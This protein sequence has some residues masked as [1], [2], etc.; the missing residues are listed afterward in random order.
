VEGA[1]AP[2]Q[3]LVS[4]VCEEFGCLPSEALVEIEEGPTQLVLDIMELRAYANA[5]RIVEQ[6][7]EASKR[8]AVSGGEMPE[9]P[10]SPMIER[11]VEI[12]Q[13]LEG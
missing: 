9:L 10:A 5:K 4:R 13:E 3:W 8:A 7:Y 2:E 1:Q 6:V 11:V 12:M